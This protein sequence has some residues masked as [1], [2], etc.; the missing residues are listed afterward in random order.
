MRA[1]L[2]IG[3]Y[4]PGATWVHRADP[5]VKLLLT[6]AFVIVVFVADTWPAMA[7][8]GVTVL[9]IAESARVPEGWLA[10]SLTP[11]L[12]L[13]ALTV[14]LNAFTVRDAAD[15]LVRLGPLTLSGAGLGRGAFLAT[16][17]A[18]MIG[19]TSLLALTTSPRDLADALGTLG[20]PLRRLRVPVE[21]YAMMMTIALR[22]MPTLAEEIQQ[23]VRARMARGAD[24]GGPPWR[25]AKT[26]STVLVPLFVGLFRR[27]DR[28]AL[29]MEARGYRPGAGMRPRPRLHPLALRSSDGLVAA[30]GTLWLLAIAAA[31][32]LIAAS[33]L[34]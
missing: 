12:P 30:A 32:R 24:F 16:R 27:A 19:G 18:V 5:R 4:V 29:A 7:F 34:G 23:V 22:F 14:L 11:V 8:L 28:L 31:P 33:G 9:V 26:W 10:R 15:V 2:V 6:L 20:G 3:S 1:P 17:I 25:R 21:E 13:L